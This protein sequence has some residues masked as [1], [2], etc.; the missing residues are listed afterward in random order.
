ML[1]KEKLVE[2]ISEIQKAME[3][4]AA[5]HNSLVGRLEEN[6]FLLE[7][8]EKCQSCEQASEE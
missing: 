7:E 3:Q 4:C 1:T 2:R 6:K 8:L 5:Q